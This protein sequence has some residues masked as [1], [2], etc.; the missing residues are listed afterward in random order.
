MGCWIADDVAVDLWGPLTDEVDLNDP[1][2]IDRVC[3]PPEAV[4]GQQLVAHF[5]AGGVLD[6]VVE[7]RSGGAL[8]SRHSVEGRRTRAGLASPRYSATALADSPTSMSAEA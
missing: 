6:V 2:G 8:G 7:K 4:A 5:D 3:L 1:R